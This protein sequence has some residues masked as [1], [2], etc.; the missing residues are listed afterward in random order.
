MKNFKILLPMLAFIFAIG[1]AFTEP[2]HTVDPQVQVYDYILDNGTWRAVP[3]Q[4][5]QG[6]GDFCRVQ[7]GTNGP[8]YDLYDE[9]GDP[10]PKPSG[11]GD[12]III[13][14]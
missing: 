2:E 9:M 5:C 7:L 12:P 6:I 1:M 14:P 3:E 10:E 13:N 4:N 8:V 11:S